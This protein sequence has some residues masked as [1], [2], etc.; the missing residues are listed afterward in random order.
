MGASGI[1]IEKVIWER[2]EEGWRLAQVLAP[3]SGGL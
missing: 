2:A 3:G 1:I